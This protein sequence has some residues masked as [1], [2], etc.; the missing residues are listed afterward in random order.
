[1]CYEANVFNQ[2]T[3]HQRRTLNHKKTGGEKNRS[4]VFSTIFEGYLAD[5]NSLA[6]NV[7]NVHGSVKVKSK[8]FKSRGE[9]NIEDQKIEGQ[10]EVV[11]NVRKYQMGI[12]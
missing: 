5:Q 6:K 9:I 7:Q 12:I 8:C 11:Q 4:L 10:N 2:T 1:M 3:C